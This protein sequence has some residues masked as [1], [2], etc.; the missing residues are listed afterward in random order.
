MH[1]RTHVWT[2]ALGLVTAVVVTSPARADNGPNSFR[3]GIHVPVLTL[4]GL[5]DVSGGGSTG[6][7]VFDVGIVATYGVDFAYQITDMIAVGAMVMAGSIG[8]TSSGSTPAFAAVLLPRFELGMPSGIARVYGAFEFGPGAFGIFGSSCAGC[9][10][11]P[12]Y[13]GYGVG[14]E[15]GAHLFAEESFSIDPY[16]GVRYL[17]PIDVSIGV[18]LV[19]LGV[20]LLGWMDFGA[21]PATDLPADDSAGPEGDVPPAYGLASAPPPSAPGPSTAP[22]ASGPD[23]FVEF[24][25]PGAVARA[26]A[27]PGTGVLQLEL[28]TSGPAARF[29]GC[30]EA[31]IS[32]GGAAVAVVVHVTP[33]RSLTGVDEQVLL[34][35]TN[36][37]LDTLRV[38]GARIELC[39]F[40]IELSARAREALGRLRDL[41]ATPTGAGPG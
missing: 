3:V 24:D 33:T 31:Q 37:T 39:G 5:T 28:R 23:W 29:E 17:R 1:I 10:D 9:G 21:S 35:S 8:T 22:I 30:T 18:V 15:V 7:P 40:T 6:D 16:L 4:L 34:S 36:A 14:G 25:V 13:G 26:W 38:E 41:S 2:L 11:S 19:S 12:E 27:N 32:A 20:S